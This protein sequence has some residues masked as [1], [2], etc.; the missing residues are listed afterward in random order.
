MSTQTT[1]QSADPQFRV[2][3]RPDR[4]SGERVAQVLAKPAFGAVFT[5]HMALVDWSRAGGWVDPRIVAYGPLQLDPSAAVFHYGQEIFEGMKAYRHADGSVWTFRPDQNA[6]RFNRSAARLALPQLPEELFVE[7]IRS[8]V[9]VDQVWVPGADQ[10]E[11]SLYLRP[12][13]IATE[14]ALGVRPSNQ[15]IFGVIA[16]PAGEYFPGG[17]KPVSIWLSED[18]VRAA[19]GGTGGAKCG[20]NYAASLAPMAEGLEQGCDQ[21]AF[22]DAIEQK[23]VEELGGMNLFFVYRDGSIVTPELTGTILEG[24]TRGSLIE[25]AKERGH[26]VIERKYSIDEWRDGAASGDLVEVFAC[27][28]AAVITPVGTLKWR[29]GEVAVGDGESVGEVAADLRR[30]LL[31]IQ[32]G[33]AEDSRGWVHR[34]V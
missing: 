15:A 9:T 2:D 3:E 7:A 28:T 4:A 14:P 32:Y 11:A 20:G 24:V 27:G 30:T 21:V 8:L 17:L 29:G 33:R 16:S 10:G 31:D 6:A 26:D 12:Y 23:W 13:M 18:Y 5:D 1:P 19:P 34:L 22:L 25:L